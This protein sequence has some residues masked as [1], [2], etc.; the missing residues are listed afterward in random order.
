MKSQKLKNKK[1]IGFIYWLLTVLLGAGGLLILLSIV[2]F[3]LSI[4]NPA[5]DPFIPIM[6]VP[7]RISENAMLEYKDGTQSNILVDNVFV[8]F[9]IDKEY[10]F[11]GVLN[12]LF[13]I[14]ILTIAYFVVFLLWKIFR[15]LRASIQFNNPFHYKNIWRIRF[16]AFAVLL[17]TLIEIS[18]P[19]IMKYLWFDKIILFDQTFDIKLNFDASINIFWGLIILVVAEIYRIGL[20][21]K[22][23]QELTI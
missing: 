6:D 12:Y 13:F 4:L 16:I 15:S 17:S 3:F 22:M 23:D 2:L 8:S 1:I 11:S 9:N 20:E 14:S 21:I 18:Y 19:F 10:G 7:L 5:F